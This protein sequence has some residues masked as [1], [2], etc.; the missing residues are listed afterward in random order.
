MLKKNTASSLFL[1]DDL[2][3]CKLVPESC[4]T[5]RLSDSNGLQQSLPQWYNDMHLSFKCG[6][7]TGLCTGQVK[8]M[9]IKLVCAAF[10]VSIDLEGN[11]LA[12]SV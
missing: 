1:L 9:T 8:P 2:K 7:S 11:A 12:V 3:Y 5:I 6:R 10:P 4:M